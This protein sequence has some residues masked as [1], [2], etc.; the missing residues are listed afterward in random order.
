MTGTLAGVRG[1]YVYLMSNRPKGTPYVGVAAD[2]ARRVW[3]HRNGVG[4][5]FV[6]RYGLVRLVY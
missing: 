5:L 3:Q 2:L 4:S 1:G 6:R